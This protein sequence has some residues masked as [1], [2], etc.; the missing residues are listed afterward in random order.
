MRNMKPE[1]MVQNRIMFWAHQNGFWLHI[2]EAKAQYSVHLKRYSK[3]NSGAPAG[4]PDLVG[5][6]PGGIPCFIELKAPGKLST[7]RLNQ[8][9]FLMEA[10]NR[11]AFA[12]VTDSENH[13]EAIW[14][15]WKSLP[16]DF[17]RKDLLLRSCG[18]DKLKFR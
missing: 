17:D 2:I 12:V 16:M 11:G 4:F 5:I 7:L 9:I 10:I 6:G 3:K 15:E 13:L 14:K 1:K 18:I 8:E